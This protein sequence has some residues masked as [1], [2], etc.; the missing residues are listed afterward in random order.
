MGVYSDTDEYPSPISPS[1]LFKA[2]VV[3]AHNLIPKLLPNSVKSIE[4][5]QG[6][7]GAGSIKQFNFV[8]GNQVKNIKNRI[9][10]IDEETLTYNYTLIEGEALKDKFASIAHEIKFEAAP[11]GGSI[12]KVTSK[13]Y[14]KGDVEINEED[15]KASKEIVLGIYKVV[16]AYLL[17]NPDVYA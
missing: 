2:L 12:S 8:E 10:E 7:G 6:D 17:Q 15:I 4:I 5:I 1:R 14:L 16:E 3:D 9:D 13:Y 11:D